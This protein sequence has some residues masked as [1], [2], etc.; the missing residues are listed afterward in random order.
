[1]INNQKII[2]MKMKDNIKNNYNLKTKNMISKSFRPISHLVILSS[3]LRGITKDR[4]SSMIFILG[5]HVRKKKAQGLRK[6]MI[7]MGIPLSIKMDVCL[8]V[9]SSWIILNMLV[10][11][12]D[13]K[14][15]SRQIQSQELQFAQLLHLLRKMAQCL[16]I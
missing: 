10:C 13:C 11:R 16:L 7:L 15:V 14:F 1:M 3:I 6:S 2:T 4:R 9:F 5:D 12:I 8:V